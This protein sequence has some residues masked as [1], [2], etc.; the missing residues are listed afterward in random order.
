MSYLGAFFNN[1]FCDSLAHTLARARR[2]LL[3]VSRV[4]TRLDS[5]NIVGTSRGDAAAAT[6]IF[7]EPFFLGVIVIY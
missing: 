3:F 7:R 6:W 4:G 1:L 5:V 2:G